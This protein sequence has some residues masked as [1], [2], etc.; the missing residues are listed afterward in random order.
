MLTKN[1]FAPETNHRDVIERELRWLLHAVPLWSS[2]L[3]PDCVPLNKICN[4]SI[5]QIADYL[6]K[7]WAWHGAPKRLGRRFESLITAL[8][9]QTDAVKLLKHGLVIQD[10]K[11]TVGE[12]DYLIDIHSDILHLEVAIKFYAG[13]GD[14][15]DLKSHHAWIGPSCQDRLDVKIDHICSHQLPLSASNNVAR[16]LQQEGLPMPTRRLGLIYGYLLQPWQNSSH[17]PADIITNYPAF[18]CTYR[19]RHEAIRKITRPYSSEYG[20]VLLQRNQW[21]STFEGVA[22]LPN[23]LTEIRIPE[24]ADC[25]VLCSKRSTNMEK[26]RLFIMPERY[27][28]DATSC[29][30]KAKRKNTEMTEF[31]Y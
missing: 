24:Q 21:I 4:G 23:L 15:K 22:E 2:N 6:A 8:L 7:E 29:L 5:V 30:A 1:Y 18:W 31:K 25:Y 3:N 28:D 20:W 10:G 11:Q 12:L 19:Q 13:I 14:P 26:L 17:K 9:E 16:L 27:H